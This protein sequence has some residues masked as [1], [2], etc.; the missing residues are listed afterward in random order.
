M[1]C[2]KSAVSAPN[3]M[4]AKSSPLISR[5]TI[6]VRSIPETI[7]LITTTAN[8]KQIVTSNGL[9]H[10]R[11]AYRIT[12]PI[13]NGERVPKI[14]SDIF[15]TSLK[16]AS[17]KVTESKI[18]IFPAWPAYHMAHDPPAVHADFSMLSHSAANLFY[19]GWPH[20]DNSLLIRPIDRIAFRP[21]KKLLDKGAEI[22]YHSS[23]L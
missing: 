15:C 9:S 6:N 20:F 10:F 22:V 12:P 13:M 21:A 17:Y 2:I 19:H 16:H 11:D 5:R 18:R 23:W 4:Q 1:R 3:I 14:K 7:R 8:I